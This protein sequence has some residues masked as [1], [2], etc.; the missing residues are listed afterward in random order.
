MNSRTYEKP[1]EKI[2]TVT[3]A[4]RA[5]DELQP[6]DVRQILNTL[7]CKMKADGFCDLDLGLIDEVADVVCGEAA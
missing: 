4:I 2:S 5:L 7:A 6:A 1:Q 3:S